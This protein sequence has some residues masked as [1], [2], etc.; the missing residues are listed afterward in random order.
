[1]LGVAPPLR[2]L[3]RAAGLHEL[4]MAHRADYDGLVQQWHDKVSGTLLQTDLYLRLPIS[5]Y[6]GRRFIIYLEPLVASG[7]VN[8]RTYG[9]DYFLV[10]A[11]SAANGLRLDQIRHTYLHFVLEPLVLKRINTVR[12]LEPLLATIKTSP[13][14]ENYKEDITQFVTESLIRAVE[15]R[16]MGNGKAPS[17]V[18]SAAADKA[19]SEGFVLARYFYEALE[20]FESDPAGFQ[21]AF[22]DMLHY[23]DVDREKKRAGEVHFASAAEPDIVKAAQKKQPPKL[24]DLAEERLAAG[25]TTSAQA[26]A[27]R[28]LDEKQ[29]DPAR[30]L[31]ILARASTMKADMQGARTYFERTLELAREPRIVA[32][33]HI[34]LGRILDLQDNRQAALVHYRA[35]L[36][37]GDTTPDTRAAAERGIEK[38]YAPQRR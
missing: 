35:A 24:L 15:A 16:M 27:R 29:E 14:E 20:R 30:A 32:W 17:A 12:R 6:L 5:G 28:V 33:S 13:L 25:D 11:P 8:A 9:S 18:R 31:F 7:H 21:D 36:T 1:V 4:W 22:G 10:L 23:I 34:Y 37:A 2:D 26:I 3:Y 19:V 38:P